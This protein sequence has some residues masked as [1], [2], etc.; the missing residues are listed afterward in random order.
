LPT[1][2]CLATKDAPGLIVATVR[3]DRTSYR[4]ETPAITARTISNSATAA[5]V[6]TK[7][8][9]ILVFS[10]FRIDAQIFMVMT[11]MLYPN[12]DSEKTSSL[13]F[14]RNENDSDK[15]NTRD[16]CDVLNS[17]KPRRK[18]PKVRMFPKI[19]EAATLAQDGQLVA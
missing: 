11:R 4:D 15:R 12:G 2:T 8:F 7:I 16:R 9:F 14:D 3:D 1:V 10:K 5:D 13:C 6:D 19:S 17:P 18:S